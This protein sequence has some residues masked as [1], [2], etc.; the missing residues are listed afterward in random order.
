MISPL[1]RGIILRRIAG[2]RQTAVLPLALPGDDVTPQKFVA[3]WCDGKR[4]LVFARMSGMEPSCRWT[5]TRSSSTAR[6]E[7]MRVSR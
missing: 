2:V 5:I 6:A 1:S 4:R 7:R 3:F